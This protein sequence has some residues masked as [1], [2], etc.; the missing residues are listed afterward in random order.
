MTL[1]SK[2][3]S[4]LLKAG[5]A[6]SAVPEALADMTPPLQMPTSGKSQLHF[7]CGKRGWRT[8][9]AAYLVLHRSFKNLKHMLRSILS[10]LSMPMY[11]L[12]PPTLPDLDHGVSRYRPR[13]PYAPLTKKQIY[14]ILFTTSSCQESNS[15]RVAR[16]AFLYASVVS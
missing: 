8:S 14:H 11:T 2:S 4:R 6:H 13:S 9:Y 1:E 7:N 15:D 10:G 3:N 5:K 12:K 16:A